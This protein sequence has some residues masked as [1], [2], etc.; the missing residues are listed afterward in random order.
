MN[1]PDFIIM[2]LRIE[3]P[4]QE[5]WT[6]QLLDVMPNLNH[7]SLP[8]NM[9]QRQVTVEKVN[10]QMDKYIIEDIMFNPF[11]CFCLLYKVMCYTHI[12]MITITSTYPA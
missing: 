4:C 8:S 9:A 10:L 6:L 2:L 7:C 5:D 3:V 12:N 11:L 1:T